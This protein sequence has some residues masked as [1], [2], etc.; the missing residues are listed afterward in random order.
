MAEGM[1]YVACAQKIENSGHSSWPAGSPEMAREP[2]EFIR[3]APKL[4]KVGS[5][6]M[7]MV[8]CCY[9]DTCNDD[10]VGVVDD[11]AKKL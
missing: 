11:D 7:K 9:D 1:A 3:A 6:R 10:D 4:N 5:A 2:P 8:D